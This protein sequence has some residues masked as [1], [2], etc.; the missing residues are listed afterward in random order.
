MKLRKIVAL[1]TVVV[2]ITSLGVGCVMS[3]YEI[4][5]AN[6]TEPI[7]VAG[8]YFVTETTTG[9][10]HLVTLWEDGNFQGISSEQEGGVP[11]YNP[12]SDQ[13]GTWEQT[14]PREITAK[15]V[16]ITYNRDPMTLFGFGVVRY[17]LTFDETFETVTGVLEGGVIG[18]EDEPHNLDAEFLFTF[19]APLEGERVSIEFPEQFP[20]H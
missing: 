11:E 13:V 19:D 12:F 10:Q 8:L 5:E 9:V 15:V 3:P 1:V 16:D 4:A 17:V 6:S 7:P 14:G 2:I 18:P 20:N